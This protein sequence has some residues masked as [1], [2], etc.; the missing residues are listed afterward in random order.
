MLI[1]KNLSAFFNS[2]F[3]VVQK[4]VSAPRECMIV[5]VGVGP[6]DPSRTLRKKS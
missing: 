2:N 5:T 4:I 3:G 6:S 1:V